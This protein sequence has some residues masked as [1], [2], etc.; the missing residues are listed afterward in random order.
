MSRLGTERPAV[1]NVSDL[2]VLNDNF[3]TCTDAKLRK[4][5]SLMTIVGGKV[6]QPGR[7]PGLRG[8]RGEAAREVV[9]KH[10][11]GR[12]EARG[13]IVLSREARRSIKNFL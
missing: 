3:L 2:A 12:A 13:P 4:I 10:A 5:K 9:A 6:V 1:G 7:L 11:R 8:H